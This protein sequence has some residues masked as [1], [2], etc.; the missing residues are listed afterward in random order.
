MHARTA[1]ATF[2]ALVDR[3][4]LPRDHTIRLLATGEPARSLPVRDA[5]SVE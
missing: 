2:R 1:V 3:P 4:N 5:G